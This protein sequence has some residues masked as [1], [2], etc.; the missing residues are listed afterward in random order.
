MPNLSRNYKRY[1]RRRFLRSAR[2]PSAALSIRPEE[3]ASLGRSRQQMRRLR[4]SPDRPWTFGDRKSVVSGKSVS[5]SVD[6]GG[7]RIIK[8]KIQKQQESKNHKLHNYRKH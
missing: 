4:S 6:L 2:I 3:P 1:G 7:R 8:K 5:E